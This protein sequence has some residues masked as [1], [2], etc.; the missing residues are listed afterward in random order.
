MIYRCLL[1]TI[2]VG[3][4]SLTA[5]FEWTGSRYESATLQFQ[6]GDLCDSGRFPLTPGNCS[7]SAGNPDWR[8]EF[9]AILQRWNNATSFFVLSTDAAVGASNPGSCSSNDPHSVFFLVDICGTAFGGSTLA[10]ARTFSFA[11]GL[12]THSDIIFNTAITWNAFDDALA[13]H[14][15]ESDFR[16]VALHE[17]GHTMGLAH[18]YHNAAIMFFQTQNVT[19]PQTDDLD[20]LKARYGMMTFVVS[21]DFSGNNEQEI[22]TVRSADDLSI[23]AEIRDGATGALLRNVPFLSS[24]FTPIDAVALPDVDGNGRLELAILVKRNSDGRALVEIRNTSGPALPRIIGFAANTTPMKIVAVPDADANGTQE[25]AVLLRRNS[26]D[27]VLVEVKNAFGATL[28]NVLWYMPSAFAF[29]MTVINDADGNTVPE[30]AVLLARFLDNRGVVEIK[31]ASGP[32]A[33]NVVWAA[34]GV[35]V[36]AITSIN[37]ADNNGVPEVAILSTRDSDDRILV[38]VKN[39]AGPTMPNAL[40]YAVE[41]DPRAVASVPD[42]DGNTVPE[43]AVLSRRDSDGRI[44]VETKNAAGPTAPNAMWY[45]PGFSPLPT[46]SIL[47]DTDGNGIPEAA[48]MLFRTS[49][50]RITIQQRNASGANAARN[51]WVSP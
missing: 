15:G 9:T 43:V 18:P 11:S 27:R 44:L 3:A 50:G 16:R 33:P 20:A 49:D 37:D 35:S 46:L 42:A 2:L 25:I 45:S 39:A 12:A 51:V 34:A 22:V 13:N 19:V 1:F 21:A 17:T 8:A 32:T 30:I 6:L 29:D 41:H 36:I 7:G 24:A 10:V 38:E 14:P 28:T 26:D 5:A 47:D 40:W 48:I 4:S 23:N 31:N